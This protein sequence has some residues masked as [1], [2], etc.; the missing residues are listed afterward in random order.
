MADQRDMNRDPISGEPGSHPVGTGVGGA[1]GAALGAALGAPFGPIGALIG[2]AIG[3]VAGGAA[4]HAAGEKIDPTGE[5][6]YWKHNYQSRPYFDKANTWDDYEPAYRY[7][8]ES[9]SQHRDRGWDTN[10]ESDLERG[11][12]KAKGKSQMAWSNAKNA[13]RDAWDRTDRTFST[14]KSTD[15]RFRNHYTTA[16]YYD[17]SFDYDRDYSPAY[18][19]GT[20]SRQRYAD[21]AWDSNL[22]ND[23]HR[24]WDRFKGGSRL[25]WDRAKLA[26][27]DAWHGVEKA[28]PGDADKDGR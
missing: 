3:A 23:L 11:W 21:R 16:S 28:I 12:D 22:E 14:Y 7:G 24:D 1:G 13:V 4:G 15:D 6:E 25:T 2:G 20:F 26:A 9:R 17:K 18:R 10:L 19:Y 8:W 5:S 27:K